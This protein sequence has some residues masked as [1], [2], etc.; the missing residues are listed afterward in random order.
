MR[1]IISLLIAILM[2]AAVFTSCGV[3]Y[4]SNDSGTALVIG[5]EKISYDLF[6][7]FYLTYKNAEYSI[8]K[9]E[10]EIIEMTEKSLKELVAIKAMAEKYDIE[11]PDDTLKALKLE[12][13][14]MENSYDTKEDMYKELSENYLSQ[15]TYYDI[16]YYLELEAL[17]YGYL[18]IVKIPTEKEDV[19][20]AIK[21]K[22]LSAVNIVIKTDTEKDGLKGEALANELRKRIIGGESFETMQ[23]Y[24]EETVKSLQVGEVS[25]VY[26][27]ELGYCITKRVQI[28]DA[29]IEENFEQLEEEY[30]YGEYLKMMTELVDGYTLT[31]E[32][33]FDYSRVNDI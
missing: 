25:D 3:K 12:M 2:L 7:Y 19:V 32:Q 29:Y 5:D 26:L 1:K 10:E 6:R 24:F 14:E 20:K 9:T 33:D 21:D 16:N 13:K 15:Q 23:D 8:P 11:L 30:Q 4:A 22:F 18:T 17:L 27:T 28:S 31:Y